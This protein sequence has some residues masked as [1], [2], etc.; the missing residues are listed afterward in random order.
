[1]RIRRGE[2]DD[3]RDPSPRRRLWRA[4][5]DLVRPRILVL[6]LVV[7]AT[8]VLIAGEGAP[9][10]TRV[11]QAVGASGLLMAGAIAL[12]QRLE[13]RTDAL[14]PHTSGRPLPAGHLSRRHV[15]WFGVTLSA[16]G[17]AWLWFLDPL[18]G[19]LGLLSS[20]IYVGLYTPMKSRT[21]WNTPVGAVAGAMPALIGAAV[22]GE[23]FGTMA[24][25]L[26]GTV[27]FWQF[28]HFM[29]IA[30]LVRDQFAAAGLRMITVADPSGRS[31]GWVAVAGCA[32]LLPMSILPWIG[33]P[34]GC[35]AIGWGFAALAL[36]PGLGYLA[37]S[38]RFARHTDEPAARRLL[39]ASLIYLPAVFAVW[40]VWRMGSI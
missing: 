10:A 9:G 23:P 25:S 18:A 4:Y 21:A 38:I 32:A 17:V 20:A 12:N 14:M 29:A 37:C 1:M 34:G 16:A 36:L 15:T 40:A 7:V 2:S 5:A 33:I 3:D 28:A 11:I 8:A 30:W 26:F 6:A 22:A 35:G 24:L 27:Y 13:H 39:R 19:G 31:A